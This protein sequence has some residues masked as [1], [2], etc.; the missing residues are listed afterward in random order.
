MNVLFS[1]HAAVLHLMKLLNV[2][3]TRMEHGLPA[4]ANLTA[5][6]NQEPRIGC[7]RLPGLLGAGRGS[8]LRPPAAFPLPLPSP[9]YPKDS[10]PEW[11]LSQRRAS[12]RGSVDSCQKCGCCTWIGVGQ[13]TGRV[14]S[15]HSGY[16][17]SQ[18]FAAKMN[19]GKRC[20]CLV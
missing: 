19:A 17:V 1:S 20:I 2:S 10:L 9:R 4:L 7:E 5:A 14:Y 6:V 13:G 15:M 8:V 3:S 12:F 11:D 18:R 16:P